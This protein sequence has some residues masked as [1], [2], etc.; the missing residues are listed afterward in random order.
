MR[1][2]WYEARCRRCGEVGR[3]GRQERP[4]WKEEFRYSFEASCDSPQCEPYQNTV[5]DA[6]GW[7]Y[8]PGTDGE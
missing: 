5:Y 8:Y 1:D 6:L 2:V 4:G 3:F 7:G